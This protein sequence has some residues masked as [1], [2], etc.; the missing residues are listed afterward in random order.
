MRHSILIIL[1]SVLAG[2]S[3][4]AADLPSFRADF[5]KGGPNPF[6]AI[7]GKWEET[8]TALREFTDNPGADSVTRTDKIHF[9]PNT[10]LTV[11]TQPGDS[12][13]ITWIDFGISDGGD[14]FR[15]VHES[16]TA[17]QVS[18]YRILKG[19]TQ[20]L[21]SV[22]NTDFQIDAG[23][24]KKQLSFQIRSSA[25]AVQARLNDAELFCVRCPDMPSGGVALGVC[26]RKQD[27]KLVA[28]QTYGSLTLTMQPTEVKEMEFFFKHKALRHSFY[29]DES[30]LLQIVFANRTTADVKVE[31]IRAILPDG[32]AAPL[33]ETM[34][35]AGKE[36]S[37]ELPLRG[38]NYEGACKVRVEGKVNAKELQADYELYFAE[39][40]AAD[41]YVLG[42][43][44]G[45]PRPSFFEFLHQNGVNG[46]ALGFTP[47]ADFEKVRK[48]TANVNDIAIRN[49]T[50]MVASFSVL[51]DVD[52]AR[53]NLCAVLPDGK[54]SRILN[55]NLPEA[56]TYAI[57]CGRR[58]A[59]F[60]LDYPAFRSVLLTSEI[61][62]FLT[63]SRSS[64][65]LK[66]YEK[67]FGQ[68]IPK[69]EEKSAV[70]DGTDG[71]VLKLPEEIKKAMPAVVPADNV[72]YKWM[73]FLWKKGFGDNQLHAKI[74]D[75]MKK[76]NP[77]LET[78]HDPFR[79]Y[80]VFDRNIG[81][82]Y[83]G[84]W[85]YPTPD[86]GESFMAIESML[87]AI[88][89][90]GNKQKLQFGASMW[91]YNS[92]FC[93]ARSLQ[94]GVQP[95][96]I[97]ME[98]RFLGLAAR[99]DKYELFSFTF[100]LPDSQME[101]RQE[102][103]LPSLKKFSEEMAA[104]LWPATRPMERE[105]R[106]V[107]M[108]LSSAGQ[109]FGGQRWGGYGYSLENG[110]LNLLWKANLP[111]NI[112]FEDTIRQNHEWKK[113]RLL[114]IASAKFLPEDVFNEICDYAEKGGR[115]LA[116]APFDGLIP[117]AE[118]LDVNFDFAVKAS[119]YSIKGGSPW[120]ALKAQ[121]YRLEQ[122]RKLRE[123][124]HALVS[125]FA[126]SDS[127]EL[128]LRTL[129]DSYSRFVFALNDRRT[130]GDHMG[131]KFHAV[132]DAGVEQTAAIRLD[133]EKGAVYEFPA[134]RQLT[135]S[136]EG[137]KQVVNLNFAPAEGK[138]LLCYPK[139]LG[140]L[141]VTAK[142]N[143]TAEIALTDASGDAFRGTV[144]VR[145]CWTNP[146]G[147]TRMEYNAV[148]DGKL[149]LSI[150]P[151]RNI[152]KGIWKCNVTEL[153]SGMSAEAIFQ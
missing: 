119:Y 111:S 107:S 125:P 42:S 147:N 118:T 124:Y 57:D 4:I 102:T 100:L 52:P 60:L 120:T 95:E 127:V 138:I 31:Q 5:A 79:D 112:I 150:R 113:C 128:Y 92:R 101:Y 7:S 109:I 25:D 58:F 136:M 18:L 81:L 44:N 84:T 117:N 50:V 131:L 32:T 12:L 19:K 17:V 3:V 24:S 72:W 63:L 148:R 43:W 123:K 106:P 132:L 91:L 82:D 49:G 26:G 146:A 69:V 85:F 53:R 152:P 98:T 121:E 46:S 45:S 139:P 86:A 51:A 56:Q 83:Y 10:E 110:M 68:P 137:G 59:A 54:F 16:G 93:P 77:N 78:E 21:A 129:Q 74:S 29:R 13:G 8:P 89:G 105:G 103:L 133:R 143:Y 9:G 67:L 37:W 65:D 153:A 75:A 6:E 70:I 87:A 39:R 80:P 116:C 1:L 97:Y 141:Y 135:P 76:V 130:E 14:G 11:V 38:A 94:A 114:V 48:V 30:L 115:V 28:A 41:A 36:H 2:Y 122:A 126:D 61:E 62:N 104:P 40:P 140:K 142:K 96:N 134:G 66:R 34:V 35:A 20:L 22:D 64:D 47:Y 144:P 149:W 71:V 73:T 151:G 55:A 27:F 99:P 33:K 23:N 108:L 90:G 15:L 145:I 88:A